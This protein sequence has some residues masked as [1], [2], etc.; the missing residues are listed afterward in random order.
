MQLLYEDKNKNNDTFLN[1][2]LLVNG[3]TIPPQDSKMQFQKEKTQTCIMYQKPEKIDS[4]LRP[5]LAC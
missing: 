4:F 2:D 5:K 1:N 3:I